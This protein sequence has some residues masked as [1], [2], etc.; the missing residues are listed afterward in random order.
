MQ[1]FKGA[2]LAEPQMVMHGLLPMLDHLKAGVMKQFA[3]SVR[4][5][6]FV[7]AAGEPPY[8]Y[9]EHYDAIVCPVLLVLGGQ[10][11]IACAEV[12]RELFFER[13]ASTDKSLL[14]FDEFAHGEFAYATAATQRV[15]PPIVEWV[16]E[17]GR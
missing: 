12:T 11:R 8:A 1:K 7:A 5:R 15:Y 2:S 9:S 4:E 10:D 17:R 16:L 14:L 13:I 3:R 6:G